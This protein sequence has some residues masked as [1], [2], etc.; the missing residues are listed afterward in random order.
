MQFALA[1]TVLSQSC[2]E[3]P[4]WTGEMSRC[5]NDNACLLSPAYT[6][7]AARKLSICLNFG[8][9]GRVVSEFARMGAYGNAGDL[10][11]SANSGPSNYQ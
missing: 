1:D 11:V 9:D 10:A 2:T 7:V 5:G 4:A 8:A 3:A 6:P